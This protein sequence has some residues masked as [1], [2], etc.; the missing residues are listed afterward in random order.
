MDHPPRPSPGPYFEGCIIDSGDQ[1]DLQECWLALFQLGI[2]QAVNPDLSP[3]EQDPMLA[4]VFRLKFG[5]SGLR[6]YVARQLP[7]GAPTLSRLIENFISLVACYDY[8]FHTR[9]EAFAVPLDFER[10]FD[11]FTRCGYVDRT[12][13]KVRW[14]DRIAPEMRAGIAVAVWIEA[15]PEQPGDVRLSACHVGFA[16]ESGPA[17]CFTVSELPFIVG[18]RCRQTMSDD[19]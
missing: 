9:R 13:D 8:G 1:S 16:P 14:T 7:A 5:V 6:E 11:L 15:P 4:S 10:V 18:H 2:L 19:A 3:W 12:G 17:G